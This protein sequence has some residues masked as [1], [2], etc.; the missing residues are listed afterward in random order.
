[1][2]FF[3]LALRTLTFWVFVDTTIRSLNVKLLGG[4]QKSAKLGF[5]VQA[6]GFRVVGFRVSLGFIRFWV[7]GH[8]WFKV[9]QVQVSWDRRWASHDEEAKAFG[10][11][12]ALLQSVGIIGMMTAPWRLLGFRV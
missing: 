2:A 7:Y 12:I 9:S 3:W 1:M 11:T 5:R 10:M 8:L 4:V 6:S